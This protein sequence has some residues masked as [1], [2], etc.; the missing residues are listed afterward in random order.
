[1]KGFD[2]MKGKEQVLNILMEQLDRAHY[3]LDRTKIYARCPYCQDSRTNKSET[4]FNI[5]IPDDEDPRWL[6][7]CFRSSCGEKGVID[8]NFMRMLSSD[9]YEANVYLNKVNRKGR[10]LKSFREKGRRLI[11]N[12]PSPSDKLSL[13]KLKYIN[14]RLGT[15]LKLN[16]LVKLKIHTHFETLYRYNDLKFPEKKAS[17]YKKLS[18][19][20]IA[21]ISAYNDYLIVRNATKNDKIKRYTV[22]DLFESE[23]SDAEKFKF[24]VIPTKVDVMTTEP[25]VINMAEGT[26]DI[27]SVYFNIDVD[28]EYK[29]RIYASVSGSTYE[30]ALTHLIRQYG[31]VDIIVNIFSDDN[32]EISVYQKICQR[33]QRYTNSIE[34]KVY[35]N[36]IADDFG[37]PKDQIQTREVN[38]T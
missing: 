26:F 15:S 10:K 12:F 11:E 34:M 5:R 8:Q 24:Y 9:N 1:M 35:Y 17:Y 19:H 2:I 27:L 28:K 20:G 36:D 13:A 23:V 30:K 18:N 4:N 33:I 21:F 38:I 32:I 6:Y 31:L 3:N 22:V 14:G 16:D 25:I 37:V 7:I 29:N